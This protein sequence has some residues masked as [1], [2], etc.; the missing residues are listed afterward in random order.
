MACEIVNEARIRGF[1]MQTLDSLVY[2]GF[3]NDENIDIDYNQ[4]LNCYYI[5]PKHISHDGRTLSIMSFNIRSMQTNFDNFAAELLYTNRRCDI[6]GLCETHLT[7]SIPQPT[8]TPQSWTTTTFLQPMYYLIRAVSVCLYVTN[9]IA[10]LGRTCGLRK[11][12]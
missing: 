9:L 1:T 6:I 12:T 11:I 2:R 3:S 5:L 10:K 8:C 7:D 4:N